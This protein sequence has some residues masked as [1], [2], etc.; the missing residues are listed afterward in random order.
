MKLIPIP[1]LMQHIFDIFFLA[2]LWFEL[3]ALILKGEFFL[4]LVTFYKKVSY[5]LPGAGLVPHYSY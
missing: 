2:V 3:R 5:F 1:K 4:L